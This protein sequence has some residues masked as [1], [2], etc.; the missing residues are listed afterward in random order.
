MIFNDKKITKKELEEKP[1]IQYKRRI[2]I[3]KKIVKNG[4]SEDVCSY[5]FCFNETCNSQYLA[6]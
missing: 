1:F 2:K 3:R 5:S 6:L 4:R